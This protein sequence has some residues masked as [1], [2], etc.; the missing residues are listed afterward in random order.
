LKKCP[1]LT[2]F[3]GAES[4][5]KREGVDNIE[6][7]FPEIFGGRNFGDLLDEESGNGEK[8]TGTED[9]EKG[10]HVEPRSP[11][12]GVVAFEERLGA[13]GLRQ[14]ESPTGVSAPLRRL[15][16]WEKGRGIRNGEFGM[17][18]RR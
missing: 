5:R 7:K 10:G 14:G 18:E 11:K 6:V 15:E 8:F 4:G 13:W 9:V 17:E 1:E 12:Q 16:A 2:G 3:R